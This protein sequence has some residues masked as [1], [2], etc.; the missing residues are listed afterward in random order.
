MIVPA[1]LI[2]ALDAPYIETGIS[3]AQQ[4]ICEEH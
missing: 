4:F 3:H 1:R 2:R